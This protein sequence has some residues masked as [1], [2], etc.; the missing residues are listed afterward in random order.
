MRIGQR[1]LKNLGSSAALFAGCIAILA[2]L[3]ALAQHA[4]Q[5]DTLRTGIVMVLGALAYRS[6]KRRR[7]G[8]VK[9]TRMRISFEITL[10]AAICVTI[11]AQNNV[12]QRMVINALT[13][14]L[15]PAWALVAY[16][17]ACRPVPEERDEIAASARLRVMLAV[18]AAV[19]LGLWGWSFVPPIENWGNPNEDGFSY[20][21]IFYTT[22]ICLPIGLLLLTGAI[23][24]HGRYVRRA[25]IAFVV[26]AGITTLVVAFLI[27]Q[28]IADN[29]DGKV[30]GIQIGFQLERLDER[31]T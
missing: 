22:I 31:G 4:P 21:P 7:L 29:N 8:E 15:V 17:V 3:L 12:A 27:V 13:N 25:R 10:L 18:A 26:A 24:G 19:M 30:F 1:L 16:L 2:G 5:L 23:A 28:H 6:A 11:L 14:V 9:S 20:V